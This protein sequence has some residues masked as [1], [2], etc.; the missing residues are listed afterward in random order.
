MTNIPK[1]RLGLVAVSR[2]CFPIELSR[3]RS[4]RVAAECRKAGLAIV[5]I[6]TVVENEKD[7]LQ[8]L[9]EIKASRLYLATHSSFKVYL[10]RFDSNVREEGEGPHSGPLRFGTETV[11]LVEDEDAVLPLAARTRGNSALV[12]TVD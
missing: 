6:P 10:P 11:L 7:A 3:K 2:D 12:N 9:E 1:V 4:L 8:A 5:R